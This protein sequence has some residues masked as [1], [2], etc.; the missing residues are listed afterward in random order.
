MRNQYVP[1]MKVQHSGTV[2]EQNNWQLFVV[3]YVCCDLS[4]RQSTL[5]SNETYSGSTVVVLTLIDGN[6]LEYTAVVFSKRCAVLSQ[7]L[8]P[9]APLHKLA[10]GCKFAATLDSL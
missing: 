8:F 7:R 1:A 2:I 6:V 5:T 10:F 3:A 4:C 9:G